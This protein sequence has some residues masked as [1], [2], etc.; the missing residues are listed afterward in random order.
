VLN[1]EEEGYTPYIFEKSGEIV[2]FRRVANNTENGSVEAVGL[3]R[4]TRGRTSKTLGCGSAGWVDLVE[5]GA[6]AAR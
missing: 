4:V 2:D 5:V 3:M 1:W 6:K